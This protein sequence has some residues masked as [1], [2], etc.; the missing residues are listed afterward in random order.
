MKVGIMGAGVV[1]SSLGK[2]WA[3]RGHQIMFSSRDP[4]SDHMQALLAEVGFNAQAGS[5]AETLAFGEVIVVAVGWDGVLDVL[6]GAGDWTGKIVIDTTNRFGPPPA[7]SV[8]SAAE[9]IAHLTGAAVVKAFNTIGAEHFAD[10]AF[11]AP[12]SMF[13]AGD[14]A[15]KA[16]VAPLVES[17][18]YEVIDAGPLANAVLVENLARLWVTLARSGYG[19]NIAFRLMRGRSQ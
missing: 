19:R 14:T 15:A 2:G 4:H 9:D 10:P 12:P 8:G 17:M 5:V 1:G 16:I 3:A 11:E 18:G 6:R 7:G 13:I